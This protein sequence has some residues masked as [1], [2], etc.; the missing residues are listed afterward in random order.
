MEKWLREKLKAWDALPESERAPGAV[1]VPKAD[2]VDPKRLALALPPSS[3]VVRV[4]NRHLGR[5]AEGALRN[6]VAGDY[7]PGASATDV[8]RYAMAQNDFMWIPE[9]E[10]RGLIPAEPK[11]GERRPAPVALALRL[12][13]F[14]LDPSRGFTEGSNFSR[15]EAGAGRL[16]LV[17]ET[18]TPE[19]LQLR[20]EGW[21]SLQ[22]PG[23][24]EP[25][26]Y[27]PAL[28]GR[29]EVDRARGRLARFDLLALGDASGLPR[30]ANGKIAFR[31]GAYPVG[32]VFELV[33]EP[34]PAERLH[35]R[36]ARDNPAAY[37]E[38]KDKGR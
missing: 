25:S 2:A 29:L 20:L 35:P 17:V 15:S 33:A 19:K 8:E 3:L 16:E 21:A 36:G 13:R 12:F 11:E 38:P 1:S 7:L 26:V 28:L 34:S 10:W 24:D 30:D 5:T 32:I 22:D 23:R 4:F 27:R 18:V 37:L 31:R 14:H 9:A 6:A